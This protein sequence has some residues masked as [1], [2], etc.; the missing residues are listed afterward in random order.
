MIA[1]FGGAVI[2]ENNN[3][4]IPAS[5]G[6][7]GSN[8]ITGAGYAW[9]AGAGRR[10]YSFT[11]TQGVVSALSD[12][13]DY[14]LPEP[15]TDS[16]L[17]QFPDYPNFPTQL[18]NDY[19]TAPL[20]TPTNTPQTPQTPTNIPQTPQTPQTPTNT[21]PVQ[22][23]PILPDL[24]TQIDP[25]IKTAK[26]LFSGLLPKGLTSTPLYVYNPPRPAE[27]TSNVSIMPFVLLAGLGI[28]GFIVYKRFVK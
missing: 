23:P 12:F 15:N 6:Y 28:A 4:I 21:P 9:I 13:S 19:P 3:R 17:P 20:P 26:E 27:T 11:P 24:P 14:R 7:I 10:Y 18:P 2:D 1:S 16:P 22:T 8:D 25:I 5:G